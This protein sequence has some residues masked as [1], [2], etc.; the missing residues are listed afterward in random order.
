MVSFVCLGLRVP[1]LSLVLELLF[2]CV[3]NEFKQNTFFD[4][5]QILG[6]PIGVSRDILLQTKNEKLANKQKAK[7]LSLELFGC[8]RKQSYYFYWKKEPKSKFRLIQI[9]VFRETLCLLKV[10]YAED[11]T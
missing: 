9:A 2:C 11:R 8:N 5:F 1:P 10:E 6:N 7:R 3:V 4:N